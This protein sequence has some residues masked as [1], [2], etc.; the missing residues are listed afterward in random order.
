MNLVRVYF[1]NVGPG[2]SAAHVI[3]AI[4]EF[5]IPDSGLFHFVDHDKLA[6]LPLGFVLSFRGGEAETE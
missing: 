5:V 2:V 6:Y 4:F 3:G 1:V